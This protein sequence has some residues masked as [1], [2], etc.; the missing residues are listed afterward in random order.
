MALTSNPEVSEI[1]IKALRDNVPGIPED[2]AFRYAMKILEALEESHIKLVT[3]Q[4]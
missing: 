3:F 1:I 2:L 4:K